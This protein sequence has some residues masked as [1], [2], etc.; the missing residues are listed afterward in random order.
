MLSALV[1]LCVAWENGF[2]GNPG[3]PDSLKLISFQETEVLL[4]SVSRCF[5]R[6]SMTRRM[7]I[8]TW[9]VTSCRYILVR[10]RRG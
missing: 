8:I 9:L 10:T 4:I 2:V 5:D 3:L 7:G 6:H 1:N